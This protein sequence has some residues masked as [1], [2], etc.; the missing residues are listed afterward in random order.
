[1]L[2]IIE[3]IEQR[4]S[5]YESHPFLEFLRDDRIPATRRL[6]YAPY[7][8]HFVLTFSDVN[9]HYLNIEHGGDPVH[10]MASRHAADDAT[11]FA[12]FLHDLAALGYDSECRLTDALRFLWS[13]SGR[14]ARDMSY[15]AISAARDATPPLRLV[16]IAA[17]EAMGEAWLEATVV[18]ARAHPAHDQLLYFGPHHL[19]RE[20]GHVPGCVGSVQSAIDLDPETLAQATEL[21]DGLFDRM[22]AFNS[23][24]LD[25]IAAAA[26]ADSPPLLATRPPSPAHERGAPS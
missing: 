18:A 11:H 10:E 5:R 24:L 2:E 25:R 22:E 1:M 3:L 15:Y 12:L 13:D 9:R 8:C 4:R 14:L 17:L 21:V 6:S 26:L 23:E 7:V 16:V 19:E 20:H